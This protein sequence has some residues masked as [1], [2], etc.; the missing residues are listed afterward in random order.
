MLVANVSWWNLDVGSFRQE[1]Q[2]E[3]REGEATI[4]LQCRQGSYGSVRGATLD[5]LPP[6]QWGRRNQAGAALV[7]CCRWFEVESVEGDGRW[8]IVGGVLRSSFFSFFSHSGWRTLKSEIH[9]LGLDC[10]KGGK[11]H[12]TISPQ[13][14]VMLSGKVPTRTSCLN[15]LSLSLFFPLCL[16]LLMCAGC[17]G[18]PGVA[19]FGEEQLPHG[20]E[21]GEQRKT[22]LYWTLPSW[23]VIPASKA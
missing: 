17:G 1:S 18:A 8:R 10:D 7:R 19:G 12:C 13:M 3:G 23:K 20:S 9:N 14:W 5:R 21:Q 6:L 4:R 16:S 11:L 2:V 22:R 15:S